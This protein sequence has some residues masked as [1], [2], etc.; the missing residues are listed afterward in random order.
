VAFGGLLFRRRTVQKIIA[1]RLER[2]WLDLIQGFEDTAV[3]LHGLRR[4]LA[5]PFDISFLLGAT[6][7][8]AFSKAVFLFRPMGHDEAYTIMAFAIRPL[9]YLIADYHLPNNHVFHTILVH[10]SLS[11]GRQPWI[12]RLPAFLAGVLLT[13]VGYLAARQIFKNR[14]IALFSAALV[15]AI[16]ILISFST[17][18]R[19][20]TLICLLTLIVLAAGDYVRQHNNK[21]G[22]VILTLTSVLGFYTIPIMVYTAGMVYFWLSLSGL[23]GDI[24]EEYYQKEFLKSIAVSGVFGA[25]F[26]LILYTPIFIVSSVDSLA[27]NAFVAPLSWNGFLAGLPTHL[28]K[29]WGEWADRIPNFFLWVS[30]SCFF[31]AIIFHKTLTRQA[32]PFPI[33][34]VVWIVGLLLIQRVAPLSRVWLFALPL[35]LMYVA[36]GWVFLTS[37]LLTLTPVKE[38]W[39]MRFY[40]LSFIL[41]I[42]WSVPGAVQQKQ[43]LGKQ[44]HGKVEQLAFF[45]CKAVDIHDVVLVDTTNA[46][47]LWYY[48]YRYDI[49]DKVL[50]PDRNQPFQQSY[51]VVDESYK[52]TFESVV[53]RLDF[54]ERIETNSVQTVYSKGNVSVYQVQPQAEYS[55]INVPVSSSP[56]TSNCP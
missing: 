2:F 35:F 36:A 29:T 42:L 39:L 25:A 18:A 55:M 43:A 47:P 22:W 50:F 37:K 20:Y 8:A 21:A 30:I 48:F 38:T 32:I 53:E 17:I 16:P 9:R 46:P 23:V 33:A 34:A 4:I 44:P 27:G 12:V 49:P 56:L 52:E 11:L 45:L 41:L 51:V 31:T 5:N 6:L 40:G 24:S 13:P 15:S 1:A 19:G 7:I 28:G 54:T 14:W 10:F 26:T 3:L